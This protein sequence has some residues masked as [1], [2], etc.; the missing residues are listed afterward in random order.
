VRK[1]NAILGTLIIVL[2]FAHGIL[3]AI[4]LIGIGNIV[5]KQLARALFTLV[6]VHAVISIILTVQSAKVWRHT[7][8]LYFRENKSFWIRRISGLAIVILIFV[9][10]MLFGHKPDG[11][12]TY[13]WL[14][15]LLQLL[16]VGSIFVHVVSNVKPMLVAYGSQA[17]KKKRI[18]IISVFSVLTVFWALAMIMYYA[19]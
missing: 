8:T 1:L 13:A 3:G 17:G 12:N 6:I 10:I 19:G 18:V 14:N 16:L 7:K 5:I 11:D 2:L 4:L 9:H 15:M